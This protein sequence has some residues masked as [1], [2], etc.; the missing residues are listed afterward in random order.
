MTWNRVINN[1]KSAWF[2]HAAHEEMRRVENYTS[3]L[4]NEVAYVLLRT[5]AR[6]LCE[7]S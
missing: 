6:V 3:A 4:N 1:L 7:S 2:E 5:I